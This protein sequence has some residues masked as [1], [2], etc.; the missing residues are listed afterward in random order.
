MKRRIIRKK[1]PVQSK[2]INYDGINFKSGLEKSMW[3]ALKEAN[4]K[5]E[6]EP[7]SFILTPKFHFKQKSYERQ[8]DGKGD[9]ID[10]GDKVIRGITYKPDFVG[11][12]FIIETKGRANDAF[13]LRWKLFKQYLMDSKVNVVLFK[14]QNKA[15]CYETAEIIR[16]MIK[17]KTIK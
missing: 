13:P 3:I 7:T 10:R 17:E 11:E 6:Y 12:G 1:G 16:N 14:P 8:S 5:A 4:I 9:Y 15:E 2:A